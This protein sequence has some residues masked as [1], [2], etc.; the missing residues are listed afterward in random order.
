MLVK[1]FTNS[2][3]GYT[4]KIKEKRQH[5]ERRRQ[6]KGPMGKKKRRKK[7]ERNRTPQSKAHANERNMTMSRTIERTRTGLRLS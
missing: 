1:F 7:K 5:K 6:L 2:N 4:N 3:R